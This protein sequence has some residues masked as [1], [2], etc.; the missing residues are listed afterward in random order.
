MLQSLTN[1]IDA[2]EIVAYAEIVIRNSSTLWDIYE[3]VNNIQVDLL[4]TEIRNLQ[5]PEYTLTTSDSLGA[6]YSTKIGNLSHSQGKI[7]GK[8]R[9]LILRR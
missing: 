9:L 3:S 7:L 2:G 5:D 8:T 6:N 1:E 4:S